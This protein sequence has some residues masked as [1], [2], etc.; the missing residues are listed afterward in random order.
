MIALNVST[1]SFAES[2]KINIKNLKN[3]MGS[4]AIAVYDS[5]ENFLKEDKATQKQ[6]ISLKNFNNEVLFKDL[7]AG[8]FAVAIY[9]DENENKK[10]DSNMFHIPEEGYGFSLNPS[11]FGPPQFQKSVF[12][13][14]K[15]E[16]KVLEIE[17]KY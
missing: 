17:M 14:K 10:L 2:I 1:V 5:K 3:N 6:Y 13:L 11:V 16:N 12:E 4:L 8:N 9:H 7:A 15:S